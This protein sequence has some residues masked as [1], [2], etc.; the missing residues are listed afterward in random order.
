M[1][2]AEIPL[3]CPSGALLLTCN[4]CPGFGHLLLSSNWSEWDGLRF[5]S[6][7]NF[8]FIAVMFEICTQQC[9]PGFSRQETK[10]LNTTIISF[11]KLF[12]QFHKVTCLTMCSNHRIVRKGFNKLRCATCSVAGGL[13]SQVL[14]VSITDVSQSL[15]EGTLQSSRQVTPKQVC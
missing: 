9:S 5:P 15:S 7:R 6:P 13:L 8:S 14:H 10:T 4:P 3:C 11:L 1:G 2:E 12:M